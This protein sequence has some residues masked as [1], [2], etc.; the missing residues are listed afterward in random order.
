MKAL[1]IVL[2][3]AAGLVV[4][5]I[6]AAV[7]V[8]AF[9]DPNDY[10]GYVTDAFEARLGHT[11]EIEQDLALSY[12][13]WLAVQTGDITIGNAPGF[14]PEPLA[15]VRRA[16]ARVKLMPLLQRQIEIGTVE[17]EGLTL[18]LARDA[19][20]NGNWQALVD[21]A[22]DTDA[23]AAERSAAG[24]P[25]VQRF[26][27]AGVSVTDGAVYWRENVSELRYTVSDLDASTGAL[28]GSG[29]IDLEL[30]FKFRDELTTREV[31]LAVEGMAE[32]AA[33]GSFAA[34]DFN[35]QATLAEP[36]R[37]EPVTVAA[38]VRSAVYNPATQALAVEGLTA[39][40]AGMRAA[41]ALQGTSM[42]DDLTLDG[43]VTTEDAPFAAVFAL[44]GAAPPSGVDPAA[45]GGFDLSATFRLRAAPREITVTGLEA[46]MLGM[47]VRGNV[48][49]DAADTV[50]GRIDIPE[51]TPNDSF[52]ALVRPVANADV[53]LSAID[54]LALSLAF[55]TNLASGHLSLSDIKAS[56][57]GATVT[58][59][60]DVAPGERGATYRGSFVTSRFTAAAAARI[61]GN[62]LPDS[63]AVDELGTI[64]LDTQFVY[65]QGQD[66][67]ALAP[68]KAEA[69]GLAVSGRVTGSNLSWSPAWAGEAH[70]AQFSPQALITRFG[71]PP[72]PTSDSQALTR[73]T[74]DTRFAIEQNGAKLEGLVLNLDDSKI[75][76]DF[77]LA[78]FDDPQYLFTLAVDRVNADRY[79]PPKARDADAGEAT[80]GDIELPQNNTMRMDGRM[81]IGDLTLAGMSFQDVGS[82]ILLGSGDAKLE[83]ARA[84]L[85]GG[86][87]NGNFHV[88][89]AGDA[90]GLALDGRATGLQ[91][92]PLIEALTGEAANFSGAG[93]FDLNLAGH[94]RTVIENVRTAGGNVSF[95][96]VE[97]AIKGFNLGRTLCAAYNVT[98]R[99]PAPPELP[100]E[101]AYQAIK[102]T[103]SVSAGTATSSDLLARTAF[104]DINGAGTLAL[105]DQEL[106]YDLDAKLTGKIEIPN[107]ETLDAH[108]GNAIPFDIR[109]T[110]TAP[111]ITPDFSKLVQRAIRDEV[112]ER[113][114]DRLQ[115]RLRDL[116]R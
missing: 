57:L 103:A 61:F 50:K 2:G 44:A 91:L 110:V 22:T 12:F 20:L 29:P 78:G 69:F 98:Q 38:R 49:L 55:D 116:L 72:Q 4:L 108:I 73:A 84:R 26:E 76:G 21:N 75:T 45:L 95:E 63:V 105:V 70:V 11:L 37:A 79:L 10:K 7:L 16:A 32:L 15:T 18:N 60:L 97:G 89:A 87:F 13:P 65:D 39:D 31:V 86:E 71:L 80:A 101:T 51:F 82:R 17:L 25:S 46:T 74:I 64:S 54:K 48:A 8:T 100:A 23:A 90:P 36:A 24:E 9:F 67:V 113:L 42:V 28:G 47:T 56:A 109:G 106:N 85:Y 34:R 92:Q 14:G 111:R 6:A 112:Q 1:K 114:Q 88:K 107:C 102:G 33:D 35:L 59:S 66:N 93:S 27:L 58:A 5:L 43:T 3:A 94:G 99:A 53:D 77:T 62:M 115:D 104:M 81:T 68:F 30:A 52:Y 41:V 83:S 40:A 96:M 19:E